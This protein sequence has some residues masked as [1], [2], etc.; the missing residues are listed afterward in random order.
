MHF[1]IQTDHKPL[2]PLLSTKC[3]DEMPIR[4]QRFRLRLMRYS[5]SIV[6]VPGKELCT[7]D[8]LSRAPV[9]NPSEDDSL[10]PAVEA[11]VSMVISSIPATT[12]RLEEISAEQ[13]KDETCKTVRKFCEE[14]WPDNS[15]L[16]GQLK[17][18]SQVKSELSVNKGLLLRGRRLIIP[19]NLR[20]EIVSKLHSGH[21][22]ISK[23]YERAKHSVWWPGIRE[24]INRTIEKCIICSQFREQR[25]EPLIPSSFPDHPWQRVGTDLLEWRKA[26]YL[27]V[28]DYYSRFIEISKLTSTTTSD[29]VKHFKSFLPDMAFRKPYPQTMVR[30]MPQQNFVTL[31]STTDFVIKQVVPD[32]PKR[33]GQQSEPLKQS[34]PYCIRMMIRT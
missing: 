15:V 32:I 13:K 11:F 3:L 19:P 22:G 10:K 17:A 30:N 27:L 2:V 34:R 24:D 14:G 4:V 8:T 5:Y 33:M 23:C 9:T 6:H 18:F 28:V 21:Q 16:K 1:S 31:Q 29:I 25:A 26:N 7:A 20:Q 12:T